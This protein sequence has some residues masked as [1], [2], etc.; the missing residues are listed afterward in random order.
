MGMPLSSKQYT[1]E[2]PPLV[3]PKVLCNETKNDK[4]GYSE[5]G[6]RR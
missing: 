5:W 6:A 1:D 2:K 4:R 3:D